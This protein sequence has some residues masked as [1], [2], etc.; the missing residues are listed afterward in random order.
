VTRL[1]LVLTLACVTGAAATSGSIS[2]EKSPS[3]IVPSADIP[4]GENALGSA[5]PDQ[6][7]WLAEY[8]TYNVRQGYWNLLPNPHGC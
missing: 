4:Q 3:P 2:A 8:G 1:H 5:H 7:A 6:V